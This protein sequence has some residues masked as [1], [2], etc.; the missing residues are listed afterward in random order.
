MIKLLPGRTGR[1]SLQL[2]HVVL[3][4]QLQTACVKAHMPA[5]AVVP[6]VLSQRQPHAMKSFAQPGSMQVADVCRH[7]L[8]PIPVIIYQMTTALQH[9]VWF[10]M[11]IDAR[12][13]V[14]KGR[15]NGYA[16]K[17]N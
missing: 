14:R 13:Q 6:S 11:R 12:G 5:A 8:Q 10:H 7:T 16:V 15:K 3:T 2:L 1:I 9:L 4:A 17:N